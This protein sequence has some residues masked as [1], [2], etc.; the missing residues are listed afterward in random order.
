MKEAAKEELMQQKEI[1]RKA[2]EVVRVGPLI[3]F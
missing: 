2:R 3:K 1:K